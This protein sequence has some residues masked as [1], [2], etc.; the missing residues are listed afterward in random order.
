[1]SLKQKSANAFVWSLMGTFSTQGITFLVS[2][3][4]A[5]LLEPEEFGLVGM[6]MVFTGMSSI[7]INM[8]FT[9][10]LVQSDNDTSI[11]RSSVFY[12]NIFMALLLFVFFY[13]TAPYIARFYGNDTIT[14][15]VRLYS[16][17]TLIASL[18]TVQTTLLVK[19][20]RFKEFTLRRFVAAVASAIVGVIMAFKGYGVYALVGQS[21]TSSIVGVI[22]LWSITEWKPRLEFSFAA[23]RE[24][25][26]YS[27]YVF[28]TQGVG[29][30]IQRSNALIIGKLF[31]PATLGFFTR[32][33]SLNAIIFKY[34]SG[35]LSKVF[36]PVL[37]QLKNDLKRFTD[38]FIKT[39]HATALIVFLIIGVA[40]CSGEFLI[41]TLFGE[42]WQPSVFIF[43][44]VILRAYGAPLN[45]NIGQAF[46]ALGKAKENFWHNNLRKLLT[47]SSFGIAFWFGFEAYLYVLPV[48]TVI[49]TAYNLVI[50]SRLLNV[51]IMRIAGELL[52]CILA[53]GIG[54]LP[55]KFMTI[56]P[57]FLNA[58]VGSAAFVVIYLVTIAA[59]A[60]ENFY[61]T[62]DLLFSYI[63]SL[64]KKKKKSAKVVKEELV[65]EQT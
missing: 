25:A 17:S 10:A 13:F 22:L 27:T 36:F 29:Q 59:I 11:A 61:R 48:L 53:F 23:L 62:K 33:N 41:I 2:I 6:A 26:G 7:F 52:K 57:L 31:S 37:S 5:R 18:N 47:I 38:V 12:F 42:K 3:V 32:A 9:T 46:L 54:L 43:Q 14:S 63:H 30:A 8:G 34:T 60:S 1:M 15:L 19:Y 24:M 64:L 4:L 28:F 21:I 55:W 16:F 35:S 49:V 65:E 51:N 44:I 56:E 39:Y 58:V 20:L 45:S 40:M 50:V